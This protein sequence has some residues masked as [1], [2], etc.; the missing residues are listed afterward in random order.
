MPITVTLRTAGSDRWVLSHYDAGE[1]CRAHRHAGLQTSWMIAGDYAE[2]SEA[3]RI[4]ASGPTL[5]VKPAGFEHANVFGPAGA[6][7]LSWNRDGRG[8]TS[9]GVRACS[10]G[11]ID[12]LR[13]SHDPSVIGMLPVPAR[14]APSVWVR[15]ARD[16]L[17]ASADGTATLARGVGTHPASLARAFRREFGTTP[18]RLRDHRRLARVLGDLVRTDLPLADVAALHGYSDQAHMTRRVGAAAGWSP[19]VLRR[20]FRQG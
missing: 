7:V 12:D 18:A 5:S 13:R 2:D 14:R 20:L 1:A 4:E 19:A 17:L 8:E 11:Q 3:G 16:R 6:L 15:H 10:D 9:Y